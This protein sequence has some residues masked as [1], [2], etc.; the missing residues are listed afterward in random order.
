[1]REFV[2]RHYDAE[3][4]RELTINRARRHLAAAIEVLERFRFALE[5]PVE[6]R[7]AAFLATARNVRIFDDGLSAGEQFDLLVASV[8][9]IGEA[10]QNR[11]V[12]AS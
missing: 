8:S 7:N 1:V 4:A 10:L 5:A 6:P 9:I 11:A 12:V 2:R 3:V